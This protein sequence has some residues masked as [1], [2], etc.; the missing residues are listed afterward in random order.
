MPWTK[1]LDSIVC[2]AACASRGHADQLEKASQGPLS[3]L[4]I[5]SGQADRYRTRR[6]HTWTFPQTTLTEYGM[7]KGSIANG[8]LIGTWRRVSEKCQL[9]D[10]DANLFLQHHHNDHVDA[11]GTYADPL[12]RRDMRPTIWMSWQVMAQ[13]IWREDGTTRGD[14]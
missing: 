13:G 10:V 12:C 3:N 8:E 6:V 11:Y 9:G 4:I 1:T 7:D 14:M 5:T 2:V